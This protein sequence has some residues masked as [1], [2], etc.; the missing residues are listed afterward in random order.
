MQTTDTTTYHKSI[1]LI[2]QTL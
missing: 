2:F 1:L